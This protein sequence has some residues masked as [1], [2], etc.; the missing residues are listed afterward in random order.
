MKKAIFLFLLL[1]PIAYAIDECR[2]TVTNEDL[3]C[4]VL[5]PVNTSV[6]ACN[7][8]NVEFLNAS[9]SL[10]NQ[11]MGNYNT[12]SC[13]ATFNQTGLGTYVFSYSTG[14]SGSIIVEEGFKVLVAI[15]I[16]IFALL[17]LLGITIFVPDPTITSLSSI[18]LMASGVYI[19]IN[20]ISILNNFFTI[21]FGATLLGV[22][23]YSIFKVN[24][25][26]WK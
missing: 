6:T 10:Y 19:L 25:E 7:T 13:N 14:D 26:M 17:I 16:V 24:W 2:G 21:G 9:T 5:L 23:F 22:G 18:G 1:I 11:T 3:P 12:F 20:G 8:I 4:L 15:V